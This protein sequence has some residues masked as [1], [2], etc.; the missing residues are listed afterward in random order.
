[1]III[2]NFSGGH[3]SGN[4]YWDSFQCIV[5]VY[6][7]SI[8]INMMLETKSPFIPFNFVV[9]LYNN[10]KIARNMKKIKINKEIKNKSD[11]DVANEILNNK[12]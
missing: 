5:Y 4:I 9:N 3:S 10:W 8:C 6:L 11:I 2:N 7:L 12:E 1:M